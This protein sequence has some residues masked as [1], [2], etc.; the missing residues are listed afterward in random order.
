ML[1]HNQ[2]TSRHLLTSMREGFDTPNP[3][4]LDHD[5]CGKTGLEMASSVVSVL[6]SSNSLKT[7]RALGC[8]STASNTGTVF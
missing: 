1:G 4:Y 6:R 5:E 2:Y 8:D 3:K 7:I